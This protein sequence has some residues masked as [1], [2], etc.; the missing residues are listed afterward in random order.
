MWTNIEKRIGV[1]LQNKIK[2][3]LSIAI[4]DCARFNRSLTMGFKFELLPRWMGFKFVVHLAVNA[5]TFSA[6]Q[7]IGYIWAELLGVRIS[8]G[9]RNF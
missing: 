8:I 1:F 4:G 2:R 9:A 5:F 6:C 3:F 7:Y